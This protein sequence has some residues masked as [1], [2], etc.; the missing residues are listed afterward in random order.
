MS[1]YSGYSGYGS[2]DEEDTP[3]MERKTVSEG[4]GETRPRPGDIC[5]IHYVAKRK[6]GSVF[7]SSMHHGR[8]PFKFRMP[9]PEDDGMNRS[10]KSGV[11]Q[12]LEMGVRKMYLG[13]RAVLTLRADYA[14]VKRIV[15]GGDKVD[16]F[17][18]GEL[19]QVKMNVAG[20][21]QWV[22][23]KIRKAHL[24]DRTYDV[25]LY[26][27]PD[28]EGSKDFGIKSERIRRE[29]VEEDETV[30][31]IVELLAINGMFNKYGTYCGYPPEHF[32]TT[33]S[34]IFCCSKVKAYDPAPPDEDDSDEEEDSDDD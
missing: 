4:D 15:G 17:G 23:G 1:Q 11:I 14:H 30:T 9:E 31:Y 24:V 28:G 3:P 20:K 29:I 2:S 6:D 13:E 10:G 21:M 22:D 12:G 7:D 19:V 16:D 34:K 33:L 25:K 27:Y 32:C 5:K 8:K 26:D 18:K